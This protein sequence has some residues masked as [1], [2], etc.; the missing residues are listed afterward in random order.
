MV[1]QKQRSRAKRE[2]L[3]AWTL[4]DLFKGPEDPKF[5]RMLKKGSQD[6]EAFRRKYAG[7]ISRIV[8]NPKHVLEMLKSYEA[9]WPSV[10]QPYQFASLQFAESSSVSGRG[11]FLQKART[12]YVRIQNILAFFTPEFLAVDRKLLKKLPENSVLREYRNYLRQLLAFQ[13]HEIPEREKQIFAE[14]SLTG[15]SAMSRLFD[16]EFAERRY[17]IQHGRTVMSR[18]LQETLNLLHSPDRLVRKQAQEGFSQGLAEDSRRLTYIFNTLIQDKEIRDRHHRF[19]EP[20]DERH[21]DNQMDRASVDALVKAVRGSYQ[22]VERYYRFKQRLLKLKT[23]YDYDRYAPIHSTERK[24]PWSVARSQVVD[25]FSHFHPRFGEI[26]QEFFAK[27][28]IDAAHRPGKQGG[29]FCA[30]CTPSTH[31]YVFMNYSGTGR[32]VFT[33]MHE[34]GHAIHAY[35]MRKNTYLNFDTPLTIAETASVFAEL[36]L[37]RHRVQQAKSKMEKLSLYVHHLENIIATV[38]RQISM[39]LFERDFHEARRKGELSPEQVNALWRSRQ[40]EMFR[41]SVKLTPNYDLW[42]S[43]IPHFVHTPFY[44]YAYSFG[45]MLALGFLNIYDRDPARFPEQYIDF[46]STGNSASP[47][48]LLKPFKVSLKKPDIWLN[49]VRSFRAMLHEAEALAKS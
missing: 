21:L 41:G 31:P 43:Y 2:S 46:L 6:A 19:S 37:F 38:H 22:D 45:Q 20:E 4:V 25:A 28:W 26:A 8:S 1:R 40:E 7:K 10:A 11:A 18:S 16:E 14:F 12:E 29:A 34:L 23:L 47:E 42:W 24:T 32:D 48:E 36:L 35:L 15:R 33:L 49:G 5:S 17:Q 27:K 9:I 3:P 13:S 30:F 44:V 39:F